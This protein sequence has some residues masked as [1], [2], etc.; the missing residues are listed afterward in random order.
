MKRLPIQPGI[1][2]GLDLKVIEPEKVGAV[3]SAT[4]DLRIY[5]VTAQGEM[6]TGTTR[7]EIELEDRLEY[8]IREF[9]G[10]GI[11]EPVTKYEYSSSSQW[12]TL[13]IF[14]DRIIIERKQDIFANW[15]WRCRIHSGHYYT[16]DGKEYYNFAREEVAT[17]HTAIVATKQETSR[18]MRT[19]LMKPLDRKL[20][21]EPIV[22]ELH[23]EWRNRPHRLDPRKFVFRLV[24]SLDEVPDGLSDAPTIFV[25]YYVSYS[26]PYAIYFPNAE[27]V[28]LFEI[29]IEGETFKY[30]EVPIDLNP[31]INPNNIGF[32][33]LIDRDDKRTKKLAP[34]KI[35]LYVNPQTVAVPG[36]GRVFITALVLDIYDNP[37]FNAPIRFNY[38]L[39][40]G[41]D[42]LIADGIRTD[43][44]GLAMCPF[45]PTLDM[46][47]MVRLFVSIQGNERVFQ[48]SEIK[49][50]SKGEIPNKQ[51]LINLLN[52]RF[53]TYEFVVTVIDNDFAPSDLSAGEV[54]VIQTP[55]GELKTKEQAGLGGI[56]IPSLGT[57]ILEHEHITGGIFYFK[58]YQNVKEC[59][60]KAY[61]KRYVERYGFA[62]KTLLIGESIYAS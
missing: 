8:T 43:S 27:E 9:F 28:R 12:L 48:E 26:L 56:E 30:T 47:G 44:A 11:A 38:R 58:P 36:E 7:K 60:I 52:Q 29:W 25:P 35:F 61:I 10:R 6:L 4:I 37:V 5:G 57:F 23:P 17:P 46:L 14:G 16:D 39:P 24:G 1:G 3:I 40:G 20:L 2:D 34:A 59:L 62:Y 53:E 15:P 55:H 50:Y 13:K 51:L 33:Y 18:G 32:L 45:R 54:I 42:I 19:F 22:F 49:V 21:N 31:F 41:G